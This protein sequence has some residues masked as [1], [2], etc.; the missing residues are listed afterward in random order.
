[1]AEYPAAD[2]EVRWQRYWA[3]HKSYRTPDLPRRKYYVLE[4][5]LYPSGDMHMGHV[6]NYAIGDVVYRYRRMQGFDVLHPFGWDAFGLPAEN[7]AIKHKNHP[8]IWTMASIET[9]R[10]SLQRLGISY[11]WEREVT[12]CNPDYYHWNQWFFLKFF[13]RG[14]AYRKEAFVN[15]CTGCQTVLA[16]EQV[17]E[18]ECYRC[19]SVV[20]KRK[21]AQWFLRITEYAQRLLDGLDA[22][23]G[24]PE[25]VAF[26]I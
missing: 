24:W 14:L 15:W 2:I 25:N 1:M 9:C 23:P 21:L 3:E 16:N 7:A 4:M 11:D 12:T 18:G 20:E 19:R 17:E 26:R 22:L 6:R 10:S 13:E 8:R 5:F